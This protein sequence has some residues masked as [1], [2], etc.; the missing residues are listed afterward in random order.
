MYED[1]EVDCTAVN[2]IH[3]IRPPS[4]QKRAFAVVCV[5]TLHK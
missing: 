5:G 1:V 2:P 3:Q 4:H